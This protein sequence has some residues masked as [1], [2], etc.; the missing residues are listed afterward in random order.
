MFGMLD[1]HGRT[2]LHIAATSFGIGPD[3]TL[4]VFDALLAAAR[5]IT[6]AAGDSWMGTESF[7]ANLP[8]NGDA[9][10]ISI[11]TQALHLQRPV[12]KPLAGRA[13]FAQPVADQ[14]DSG[15]WPSGG[16]SFFSHLEASPPN[17]CDIAVIDGPLTSQVL[18]KYDTERRP[19][20][21]RRAATDRMMTMFARERFLDTYGARPAFF[22][23]YPYSVNHVAANYTRSTL[24]EYIEYAERLTLSTEGVASEFSQEPPY[25]AFLNDVLLTEHTEKI[26]ILDIIESLGILPHPALAYLQGIQSPDVQLAIGPPRSGA[27]VHFHRAA[28]NTLAYGRKRWFLFPPDAAHQ[29]ILASSHWLQQEYST[30]SKALFSGGETPIEC[31]QSAG[32]ALFV[33]NGWAHATIN[34]DFSVAVALELP[35]IGG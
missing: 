3:M 15:G 23:T 32:D 27:P 24:K 16:G 8:C 6:L 26:R 31:V 22:G 21:I 7:L 5:S 25:Y 35:Y 33:P 1:P 10:A 13:R 9:C 19:V 18:A 28:V 12:V 30:H 14:R 34:V 4:P 11:H 20:L 2:P 17:R 29:S